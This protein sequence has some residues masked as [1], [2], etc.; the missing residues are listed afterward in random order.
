M[1]HDFTLDARALLIKEASEVLEALY[2]LNQNGAFEPIGRL[3]AVQEN[4][5]ARET[6][7]RLESFFTDELAAGLTSKE[8]YAKLTKEIAFTWLNRLVAF[9]MM[10]SRGLIRQTLAK[11]TDSN[12]FLRW[13]ARPENKECLTLFEQGDLPK[14]AFGEGPRE[15]AYRQFLL[16]QCGSVSTEIRVLFDTD[17]LP[18]RLFPRPRVLHEIIRML[19][20]PELDEAWQ[21]GNEETIGWVYQ[22]FIEQEK[23]E[24][25]DRLYK[26]KQKIRSQDIPAAT[27]LFTPRWIVKYLVQNTLGRQ[28][29][30]MHPDTG[31]VKQL[32]YL[33]PL[34]GE[35]PPVPLKPVKEITLLDPACGT[36]HFGLV[37][38]DLFYA[39]YKEEL[40]RAGE[41]GWPAAPSVASEIDIPAA[42]IANNIYGI[43]ID[44][45]AVQ[46]SALTLFLKAKSYNRQVAITDSN[47]ASADILPLDGK[48][49][50]AFLKDVQLGNP[51]YGR[52]LHT[53]LDQLKLA[54]HLGSLLKIEDEITWLIEGERKNF[55]TAGRQLDLSGRSV[56]G[57]GTDAFHE[58]FWGRLEGEIITALNTFT[59]Q[60]R[61]EGK[62]ERYFVGETVKGI[63]LLDLMR[64]RYDVV[65]ANP[66]YSGHK[67]MNEVLRNALKALYP[68]V[69][70]D[71]FSVFI[72]RCLKLTAEHGRIGMVAIHSFM[73]ISSYEALRDEIT[74]SSMIETGCH[75]GTKTEFDVAN[76]TAQGFVAFVANR[77]V[78]DLDREQDQCIGAWFRV[79]NEN[80]T[81]KRIAFEQ[82]LNAAS[83]DLAEP[84]LFFYPQ[85]NFTAIPGSPW[86]YWTHEAIRDMFLNLP[87]LGESSPP[88]L[89]LTT[90]DNFRF[91]RYWWEIGANK[92]SHRAANQQDANR[93]SQKWFPYMKGGDYCKWYGNNN[94]TICWEDNGAE[95]YSLIPI[96]TIRNSDYYFKKGI[97][98]SFL[99]AATFNARLSPGGFI[100]DVAGSSLF[101]DNIPLIL[102]ILNSR[103]ANYLLK[104]INPTVNFQVGDLARLPIP[105]KSSPSLE[106]LVDTAITLAKVDSAEDE[107]T[108]DFLSPPYASHIDGMIGLVNRRHQHLRAVEQEIDDE[109]YRLYGITDEDRAAIE[110]EVGEPP[111]MP[112]PGREDV[113]ARWVS[114]AAGIA[115]GR[116]SPGID[117]EL[118][119]AI[120]DGDHLFAPETE[121]LLRNLAVPHTIAVL[122]ADHPLDLARLVTEALSLTLGEATTAGVIEAIGGNPRQPEESLRSFLEKDFFKNHLQ[123]YRK[124]PIYWLFQSPKKLYSV[125]LFHER[126][127]PDTLYL[128]KGNRYLGGK[129]NATQQRIEEVRTAMKATEG[130]ERKRLEKEIDQLETFLADL[131]AF[132][133]NIQQ[134]LNAKNERGEVVGWRPELDDGVILNLAPLRDLMPSWKAEPAKFW[135]SLEEGE[136]D[137]SYTAMRYWPD[138]VLEKCKTN[139][140]YAIAH[141]RLDIYEG[142]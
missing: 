141:N 128:L 61:E 94:I 16:W 97:T 65:V 66:P 103:L 31:L 87:K 102:A 51:L 137:W 38:F 81:E 115:M 69:A 26:K 22:Y 72:S 5:Y 124:R 10:E 136:Y 126:I 91:L 20:D 90:A 132:D 2:G 15:R 80:D 89:G 109:V 35:I 11:G 120:V 127:T 121:S 46:L 77:D 55:D 73:F 50:D 96:S 30:Q 78:M 113:G 131:Q 99:T 54:H 105:T 98:Y 79:V 28:W 123:W 140:S 59:E 24:I 23:A 44:L 47:L 14:N 130:R 48:H 42:I 57:L 63:R 116:F 125:Y 88:R 138:R 12:G 104:L 13:L 40:D 64:R 19:N 6:R 122:D 34:K 118:G 53:L 3:P 62:D 49:L 36:M 76:K 58:T 111:E 82:A 134:V 1:L 112:L 52:I 101:P 29:L 135:K 92:I 100:F 45:R 74:G 117:R 142:A 106:S 84:H 139:K 9:R 67:N 110:A 27:Q 17:T 133:R 39:M 56:S 95:L 114:Y 75:L 83:L 107:T 32:D 119:S 33:V 25:F 21:E 37:A 68:R 70:G 8:A 85:Q 93:S 71:L 60:R 41:A 18:S 108:Y 4:E 7:E 43:D 86:V 129:I